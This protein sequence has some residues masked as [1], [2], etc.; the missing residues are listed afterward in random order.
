VRTVGIDVGARALHLVSL[1]GDARVVDTATL[2]ATDPDAAVA[3]ADGAV[4]VAVDSPDRWS[5]A[6]HA[7]DETLA[8]KFRT[9][10]CGE[11]GLGRQ[12]GIWVPWT[13][14]V[15]PSPGTWIDAGIALFSAL[16][17]AGHEPVEVYPHAVFRVLHDG[18]RP[19][20]KRTAEGRHL[21]AALLRAA[22]VACPALERWGHDAL[23]A[24]AAALVALRRAQARARPV[25]CGHDGT[26]IWLPAS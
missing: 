21:R 7:G 26:A 4:A 3:F 15:E 20:N 10:R 16:R 24:A 23:D 11:V 18:R 25:T 12:Q 13:T 6:P 1:D 9:A 8:P 17:A 14:P 2:A 19:L 5:T 22:G